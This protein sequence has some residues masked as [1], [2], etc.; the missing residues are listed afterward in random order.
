MGFPTGILVDGSKTGTQLK[1][2]TL[3]LRGILVA[4]STKSFDTVG[5]SSTTL[6]ALTPYLTTDNASWN[7]VSLTNTSD[8]SLSAPYASGASFNPNPTATSPAA[9]NAASSSTGKLGSMTAVSYRGACS[10]NDTWWKT[11][12]K[13]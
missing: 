5:T 7:N 9:S 2:G 8:V 11:W 13:F 3:E 6:G 4:G 1:S 12:T 10:T